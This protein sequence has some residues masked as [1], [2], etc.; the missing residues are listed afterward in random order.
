MLAALFQKMKMN[1]SIEWFLK[2]HV[3]LKTGRMMLN[4]LLCILKYI[5]IEFKL[6]ILF[7][8]TVVNIWSGSKPFISRN[9]T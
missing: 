9:K 1:G 3:T 5:Q 7:D 2:G 8:K 4:I 6:Y